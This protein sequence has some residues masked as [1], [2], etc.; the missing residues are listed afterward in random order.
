MKKEWLIEL[1]KNDFYNRV[2]LLTIANGYMGVKGYFPEM[3]ESKDSSILVIGIYDQVGEKWKEII[4]Q[5]N[6]WY[7]EFCVDGEKVEL[8]DDNTEAFKA[9]LDMYCAKLTLQYVW[10]SKK[11]KRF[12]V[13]HER[14]VCYDRRNT[15]AW[16]SEL[17][18]L[19][20]NAEVAYKFG[21]D[22]DVYDSNGPHLENIACGEAAK[23]FYL[24]ANTQQHKYVV[25][26]SNRISLEVDGKAAGCGAAEKSEKAIRGEY[27]F[28]IGKGQTAVC[29]NIGHL[30]TSRDSQ[31]AEVDAMEAAAEE[32]KFDEL[33]LSHSAALK[34]HWELTDV[35]IEGDEKAQKYMR[36]N[37]H[38]LLTSVPKDYDY[39]FTPSRM[40]SAQTYKG[41]IFWEVDTYAFPYFAYLFP[42]YAKNHLTYRYNCL[43]HALK[44][45]RDEGYEGAFYAWESLDTGEEATKKF[46]QTDVFSGK[47]LRNY[48]GDRQYH[49]AADVI[50]AVWQYYS[51][52]G[53]M[54]YIYNCGLEMTLQVA[55]FFASLVYYKKHRDRYEIVHTTCPDEYHEEVQNNHYTNKMAKYVLDKGLECVDSFG[56]EAPAVLKG[57]MKR[58]GLRQEELEY[59]QDVSNKLFINREDD[60]MVVEQHEGY[61][62]LEDIT[63]EEFKKTR[64]KVKEEYHGYP[65]G[66]ATH[67]QIIKQA[68]TVQA[69]VM[70]KH[71]YHPVVRKATFDY[72]NLRCEHG[73]G[74]SPNAFGIAA[75]QV[76]DGKSAY[77]YFMKSAAIDLEATNPVWKGG[78]YLGGLH[79][80]PCGGTWQVV[81]FG[82]FGI[83]AEGDTVRFNPIL[84]RNWKSLQMNF[85]F[86][87]EVIGLKL[88]NEVLT[89]TLN[90]NGTAGLKAIVNDG[91]AFELEPGKAVTVN[92]KK[93]GLH[94]YVYEA[95]R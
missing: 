59:W 51:V 21:I 60:R 31:D 91:R 53:D 62:Q 71:D 85:V 6:Y 49:I 27:R 40:L 57:V 34:R 24:R 9:C 44:K 77:R 95:Q 78:L 93:L 55:R 74:D 66:P 64:I 5:P 45:A 39:G 22:A 42:R 48:Y 23:G 37:L 70:F 68:D 80:A 72:Y 19:G 83:E 63:V 50:Y 7:S 79:T 25:A 92:Y 14:I 89:V 8:K 46:V 41:A 32:L 33:F 4:N 26:A 20:E 38:I 36:F 17:R 1:E 81:A 28:T 15:A 47:P 75:A 88:D 73:S 84:P 11:G 18:C 2:H 10:K 90:E 29:E 86:K 65:I 56:V 52:T 30:F 76:G 43:A 12:Q 82:F 67:T 94:N 61:F 3:F 69:L 54:D 87:G 35:V 13:K 16:K 58:I